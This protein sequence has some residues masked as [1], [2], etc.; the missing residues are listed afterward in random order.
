MKKSLKV[1]NKKTSPMWKQNWTSSCSTHN[2][3]M[4]CVICN[5]TI[6]SPSQA[7]SILYSTEAITLKLRDAKKAYYSGNPI[8]RD[9]EYDAMENSLRAIN[10]NAK[11]LQAVGTSK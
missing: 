4:C 1:K 3:D 6:W 8:M 2:D 10:P 7:D 5:P 11:I 9:E